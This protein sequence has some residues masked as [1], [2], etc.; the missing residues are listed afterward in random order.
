MKELD[1]DELD[2]AVNTLISDVPKTADLPIEDRAIQT[3]VIPPTEES[4]PAP[5]ASAFAR[6]A[7]LASGDSP[8]SIVPERERATTLPAARRGGRFMDVVHPS[9][10]MKTA[11]NGAARLSSRRGV[12]IEPGAQSMQPL[13]EPAATG[14]PELESATAPIADAAAWPDPLDMEGYHREPD[15]STLPEQLAEQSVDAPEAST[16]DAD[17]T[18]FAEPTLDPSVV[19]EEIA[20][21]ELPLISPFLSNTKIEKRPL[22]AGVADELNRAP[23][24]SATVAEVDVP[25]AAN[26]LAPMPSDVPVQ[27]PE[28]LQND[29][30]SIESG[31][32][33]DVELVGDTETAPEVEPSVPEKP[34]AAPIDAPAG[35]SS[36]QQQYKE[37]PSTGDQDNGGIYD[38]ANIHQPLAHPAKK[39]SGWL[40]VIWVFVLLVLG[41]AG[42]AAAY[43]YLL[44]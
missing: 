6:D 40:W 21:E 11:A 20:D 18:S 39:K 30:I 26:Q 19:E 15:T 36:I 13:V 7:P 35:P 28:E 24:A 1:F 44:K 10:D 31:G 25:D 9:S 27:L 4:A 12:T 8:V 14:D 37:Q 33:S 16:P 43:L 38:T 17:A 23:V 32:D 41:A 3:L 2:R 29:L 22:G 5:I 42:G 34:E